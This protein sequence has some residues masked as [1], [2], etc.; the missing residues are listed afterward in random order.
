MY[1]FHCYVYESKYGI[2]AKQSKREQV[3]T[4]EAKG[5]KDVG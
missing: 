4:R 1:A 3:T 2:E 5:R